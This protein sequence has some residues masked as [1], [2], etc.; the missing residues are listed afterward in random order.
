MIGLMRR[1]LSGL[2]ALTVALAL[3]GGSSA[4]GSTTHDV[5]VGGL[6]GPFLW[7]WDPAE[8]TVAAGDRVRWTNPSG[9]DHHVAPYSGDWSGELHV[10]SGGGSVK[11]R[12]K[13]PGTYLYRCNIQGHSQL[14]SGRCIGQCGS[15]IVE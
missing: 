13:K 8:L 9:V 11:F 7:Q 6:P 2:A 1:A 12:F 5:V 14:I 10:E 4:A 15:V 3:F